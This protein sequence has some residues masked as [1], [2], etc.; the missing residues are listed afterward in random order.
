MKKLKV[1]SCCVVI[2]SLIIGVIY[3]FKKEDYSYYLIMGDYVSNSQVLGE[4]EVTSFSSLLGDFLLEN[5]KVNEVNNGYLKNNMTSKSLLEMIEKDSY[6]TD[7]TSLTK[8]I[9]DSKYITITLGINDVIKQVKYDTFNDQLMYDKDI[10]SNKIEVFKHNYHQ[11]LEEIKELN[12]RAVVLLVG[13]YSVYGDNSL[14]LMIN[15]AIEEVSEG[16]AVYVD[17]G[18][19]DRYLYHSNE[20]YL[21]DMGQEHIYKK[22]VECIGN[23]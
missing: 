2:V 14:S 12:D 7:N 1:I 23:S 11:I 18:D 22:V 19:L 21:T 16:Y 4:K 5:K 9:K 6:K 3:L 8:L 10:I 20:L 15:E 17:V 13:C